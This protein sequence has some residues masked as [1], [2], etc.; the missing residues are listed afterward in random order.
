[1]DFDNEQRKSPSRKSTAR[2]KP[3]PTEPT[4]P[5]LTLNLPSPSSPRAFRRH[6]LAPIRQTRSILRKQMS[7]TSSNT[8]TDTTNRRLPTP[9]SSK[10]IDHVPLGTR[11]QRLFGGSEYFAQI[12]NELEQQKKKF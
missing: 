10:M 2:L 1:M 7:T 3:L 4:N 9:S 6:G 12:M 11:S 5:L 8:S